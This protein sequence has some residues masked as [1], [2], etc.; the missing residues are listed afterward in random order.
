MGITVG[1]ATGVRI[2]AVIGAAEGLTSGVAVEV[3]V[4]CT[5]GV[6][7]GCTIGREVLIL[8]CSPRVSS[9]ARILSGFHKVGSA[10]N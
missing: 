10:I 9:G 3:A 2:E 7:M 4:G 8:T 1:V 5:S 6:V